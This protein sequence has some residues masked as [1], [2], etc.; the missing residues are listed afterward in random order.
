MHNDK[1][2]LYFASQFRS[3][4]P[5]S[6]LWCIS[7][8][9]S[10]SLI[11]YVGIVSNPRV[12]QWSEKLKKIKTKTKT[13]GCHWATMTHIMPHPHNAQP[14]HICRTEELTWQSRKTNNYKANTKRRRNE[15]THYGRT[16]M[17][18][19]PIKNLYTY[20]MN[21]TGGTNG[22]SKNKQTNKHNN[23][24]TNNKTQ[25]KVFAFPFD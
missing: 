11:R 14:A 1:Y 4:F 9:I 10:Y 21:E 16:S 3:D 15:E 22:T 5:N 25:E 23:E 12:K 6:K 13:I 18:N 17:Q 19:A 20:S 2:V 7:M 24:F 8:L